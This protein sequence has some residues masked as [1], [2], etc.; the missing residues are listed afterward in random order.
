MVDRL[1]WRAGFGPTA[2]DRAT[3]TGKPVSEAG[4]LAALVA[5]RDSAGPP[6]TRD[7]KALDPTGDDTDLVLSWVDRMVRSHEPV[8]RAHGRSSGTATSPTRATSVSPP[9]L[10]LKQNDLFRSAT[11]T[12]APT[13]TRR[14]ATSPTRSTVDPSMLR[15]LTGEY[16]VKGAPNENYA[17]ELMELFGLGVARRERQAE[18]QRERR[19]PARQGVLRLADRRR[20]PDAPKSYFTPDR[21]YNGPKIVFGKFGNYKQNEA[22]D[23]VLAHPA[24]APFLVTKLW[25]EF[26]ATPPDAA[27]LGDLVATY[28][29]SG[30]RS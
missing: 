7:G 26:V 5:G 22:V 13:R 21:W 4:R 19:A 24:H 30:R 12:S 25:S 6:G 10:L 2:A 8:R 15:Y 1:F 28:T 23:L 20:D 14:S 17:R 16:N 27:T 18:L 3:W 29:G 11:P 9:Q